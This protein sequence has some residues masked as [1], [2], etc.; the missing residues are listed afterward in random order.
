[1]YEAL[2]DCNVY[3]VEY[4]NLMDLCKIH[5]S[6]NTLYSKV[7]EP[8]YLMYEKRLV[9]LISLDVKARYSELR[10]QIKNVDHLIP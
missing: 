9:E 7:L 5:E 3:E 6:V 1:M 4:Y 10:K 2:T 8:I